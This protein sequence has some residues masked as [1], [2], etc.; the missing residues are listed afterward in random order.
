MLPLK[1]IK[2]LDIRTLTT[3]ARTLEIG[4]PVYHRVWSYVWL[5]LVYEFQKTNQIRGMRL[6][7]YNMWGEINAKKN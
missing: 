3:I 4:T 1:T 6:N 7:Y 5:L 2:S